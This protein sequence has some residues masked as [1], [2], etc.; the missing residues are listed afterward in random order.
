MPKCKNCGE[1]YDKKRSNQIVCSYK[2]AGEYARQKEWNKRKKKMKQEL[3]TK[4]DYE[5]ALE[6]VFNKFIRIRDEN[7]PCISCGAEARTFKLTAGHY[8][9]AGSYKNLR[10][11]ED[12]VHGQCWYNCNSMKSGNLS[13]YIHGLVERIGQERL[14]ELDNQR[15]IPAHYTI[16]ELEEMIEHYKNKIKETKK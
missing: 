2:C 5:K 1:Q 3:K 8:Y 13:E 11:N 9:P 15:N 16:P 6:V 4:K 12:N 7:K 10:F 14:D